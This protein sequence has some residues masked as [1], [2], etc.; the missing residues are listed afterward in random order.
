MVQKQRSVD[1]LS[2]ASVVESPTASADRQ[3]SQVPAEKSKSVSF[4]DEEEFKPERRKM[5][6][7]ER[8]HWAYSKIVMQLNVSILKIYKNIW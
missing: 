6:V 2:L 1:E 8:W 4:E 7:K 5:T 3:S